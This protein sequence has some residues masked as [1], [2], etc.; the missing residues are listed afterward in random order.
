M[1][2]PCKECYFGRM[3]ASTAA[4]I[5][6]FNDQVMTIPNVPAQVC[7]VCGAVTYD[8]NYLRKLRQHLHKHIPNKT[9]SSSV[10]IS[11]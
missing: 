3:N 1:R 5:A 7:D 11:L 2:N 6:A 4:F 8:A 9:P 10:T